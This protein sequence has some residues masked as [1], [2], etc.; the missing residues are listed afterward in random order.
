MVVDRVAVYWRTAITTVWILICFAY[1]VLIT[2]VI[3]PY[4]CICMSVSKDF[5]GY[6]WNDIV[7]VCNAIMLYMF[8]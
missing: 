5:F 7:V 8:R 1:S 2:V 3:I 4:F 6:M